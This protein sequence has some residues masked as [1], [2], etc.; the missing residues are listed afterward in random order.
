VNQP[1]SAFSSQF[2]TIL[3][4]TAWTCDFYNIERLLATIRISIFHS[5]GGATEATYFLVIRID[6]SDDQTTPTHL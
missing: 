6:E 1:T 2:T 5:L 4:K 3:Y